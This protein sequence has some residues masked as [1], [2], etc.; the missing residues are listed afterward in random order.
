MVSPTT[1]MR[2]SHKIWMSASVIVLTAIATVAVIAVWNRQDM[3]IAATSPLDPTCDLQ[4][5]P[6]PAVFPDGRRITLSILPRPVKGVTP[7]RLEVRTEG[8]DA[9]SVEVDFR[10]LG[11]NMG[12]NR[13]RLKRDSKDRYSGPGMLSVCI[14]ERMF[15]EATVL[16][17]TDRG[18]IAAPFRF[19]TTR[20]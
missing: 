1:A 16:A 3:T 17:D 18:V 15:W 20:R 11:M 19:T 9:R 7:L 8:L 6:C 13:P 2:M 14:L 4:Q 12:H 5:G 10:G